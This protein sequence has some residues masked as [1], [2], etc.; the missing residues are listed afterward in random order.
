MWVDCYFSMIIGITST[1]GKGTFIHEVLHS[2]FLYKVFKVESSFSRMRFII[3]EH[4]QIERM[5]LILEAIWRKTEEISIQYI[6]VIAVI[7]FCWWW[8][9]DGGHDRRTPFQPSTYTTWSTLY[10]LQALSDAVHPSLES[11]Q[12]VWNF[13]RLDCQRVPPE[14]LKY[15]LKHVK[16]LRSDVPPQRIWNSYIILHSSWLY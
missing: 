1:S 8:P 9:D 12:S 5:L 7:L 2:W 16:G 13:E 14:Y 4:V 10:S 6:V 3:K 11:K 15:L